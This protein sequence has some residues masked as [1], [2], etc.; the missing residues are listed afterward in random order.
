MKDYDGAEVF[1]HIADEPVFKPKDGSASSFYESIASNQ[2]RVYFES[3]RYA[4]ILTSKVP[5]FP[6][7]KGDTVQV[8]HCGPST[9][10]VY[11]AQV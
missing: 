6:F 2:K 3:G 1:S 10:I 7:K 11:P 5:D 8:V 9:D 4:T